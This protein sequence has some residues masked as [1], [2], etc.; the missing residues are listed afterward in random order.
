[1]VLR[2]YISQYVDLADSGG[3]DVR[4]EEVELTEESPLVGQ[5]LDKSRIT[6]RTGVLVLAMRS[7]DGRVAATPASDTMLEA[8]SRLVVMGS[9]GQLEKLAAF[10][11]DTG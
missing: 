5:T 4:L 11:G 10:L 6:S 9:A 3:G 7:K 1:M 2:P 8:G